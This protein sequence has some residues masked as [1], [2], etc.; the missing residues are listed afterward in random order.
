MGEKPIESIEGADDIRIGFT[1]AIRPWGRRAEVEVEP[2][3]FLVL[4]SRLLCKLIVAL[5]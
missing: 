1:C 3:C 4:C 5:E 2:E